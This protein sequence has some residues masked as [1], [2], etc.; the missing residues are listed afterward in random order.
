VILCSNSFAQ[1]KEDGLKFPIQPK[2]DPTQTNQNRFDL[3]D[4]SSV[5]QTIVYDTKTKKYI[6]KE[7]MGENGSLNYRNPSMMTLK[8]YIDYERKKSIS[9]N[10]KERIDE[11]TESGQAALV[12]PI[13]VGGKGF[14]NFFGSDEINIKPQGSIEVSLGVNTS[15]YDNPIL[16]INQRKVTRFDFQQNMQINLVGQIGTKL[17]LSTSYNSQAAF[18]FENVTKLGYTGD[19]DQIIQKIELGNVSM[20]LNTSLI[21][22]SQTLFGI[23]TQW[24][25][26]KLTIDNIIASSKGKKQEINV[27]GKAQ[28]QNFE[29]TADN[30]ES[31]RHY[32]IGHY[33]RDAYDTAMSQMPIIQSQINITRMEVWLYQ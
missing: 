4:P 27:A 9:Q 32:F 26:G 19:E 18:D 7:S 8:E 33:F 22:G 6:F 1:K 12:P 17:K 29:L 20:P 14:I 15:R 28:V 23:K 25:F 31:N 13:K 11:Q 30:Y 21:Q 5:Q 24:K 10:W 16:P 2:Y 3:G